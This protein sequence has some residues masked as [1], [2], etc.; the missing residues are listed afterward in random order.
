[1]QFEEIYTRYFSGVYRYL[2]KLTGDPDAAEELASDTFFKA[3]GAVDSFRGECGIYTWL[4]Q[5]AKNCWLTYAKKRGRVSQ[6][7]DADELIADPAPGVE[8]AVAASDDAARIR[9]ILH[10]M[11]ETYKEVFLWRVYAE[12]PFEEIGSLFGKT[13]NWACV[14]YHRAKKMIT[15]RMEEEK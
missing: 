5:I 14:T 3:L 12:L 15:D 1:M 11:P 8:E 13:A 6:F 4:C 9:K 7:E 2:L 10:T